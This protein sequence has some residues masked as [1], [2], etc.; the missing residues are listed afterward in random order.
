MATDF[1]RFP[2][3]IRNKVYEHLLV[4]PEPVRL[5]LE[6]EGVEPRVVADRL[7]NP[8]ALSPNILFAN[9][10]T[11]SEAAS[12]LYSLNKF[13]IT[14]SD[15]VSGSGEYNGYAEADLTFLR[16][17]LTRIGTKNASYLQHLRVPFPTYPRDD[18]EDDND[19]FLCLN[20]R[21]LALIAE[22]CTNLETLEMTLHGMAKSCRM[23]ETELE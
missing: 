23:L 14:Y 20:T 11:Q 12:V 3:E 22:R 21:S 15:A 17:F 5:R 9:K 1:F 18:E 8:E 10:K 6:D 7:K 13:A 19:E 4:R 16:E 2:G